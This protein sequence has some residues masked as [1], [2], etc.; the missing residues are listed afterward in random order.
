[1]RHYEMMYILRP[2]LD[3]EMLNEV[4]ERFSSII[5]EQGGEMINLDRWG[6]RRL[7]YEIK[8]FH[9]GFYVLVDFKGEVAVTDELS[10]RMRLS[11]SVLRHMIVTKEEE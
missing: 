11:D 1:M 8:D 6:K 9:E 4:I 2:D 5:D 10:R 3:E 7:G